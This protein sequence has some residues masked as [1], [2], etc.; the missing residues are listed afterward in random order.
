MTTAIIAVLGT[1]AGSLLTGALQ[2]YSQQ[3]VRRA[4]TAATRRSEGLA[5]V[6]DL[7]AALADHRRAMWVRED[8]RLRRQDWTEARAESHRTRSAVTVPLLRVQLLMPEVAPAAQAA[9]QATYALRGAWESGETGLAGR[10]ERA[11]AKTDELVTAA[12]C[13]LTADRTA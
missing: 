6:A 5:A 8:L 10:R 4:D 7:A 2:H 3:A 9:A 12:G 13:H 11:I 1:L